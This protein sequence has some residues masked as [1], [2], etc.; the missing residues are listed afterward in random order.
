MHSLETI[1]NINAVRRPELPAYELRLHPKICALRREIDAISIS[2]EYRRWLRY[3]LWR[4]VDQIIERE[5]PE[6][7]EG[8]SNF[9]ALQQVALG[10]RLEA[11]FRSSLL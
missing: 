11:A 7:N 3:A 2:H 9:E 1:Q 8:W 5:E 10:D 4:Y 6:T